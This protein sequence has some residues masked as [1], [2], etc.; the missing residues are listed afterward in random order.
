MSKSAQIKNEQSYDA[1]ANEWEEMID[2]NVGHIYWEKPVMEEQLPQ[3]LSG[4]TVICIGGS[5]L[6]KISWK[7]VL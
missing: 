2:R 6:Y 7:V 1:L 5:Y 3:N 4:K